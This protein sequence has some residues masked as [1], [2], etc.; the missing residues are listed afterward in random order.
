MQEIRKALF[1]NYKL[2]EVKDDQYNCTYYTGV[3]GQ[4]TYL[5]IERSFHGENSE[6]QG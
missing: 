2:Y 4:Q 5:R 3:G 6:Y 1:H